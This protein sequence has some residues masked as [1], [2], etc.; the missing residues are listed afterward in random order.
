MN[1]DRAWE[2]LASQPVAVL[3]TVDIDGGP[4]LVPFVFAS[5]Q[6]RRLISAVDSKPKAS[7]RLRRLENIR[8]DSRVSVLAHHYEA[9]WTALWWVRADG[10]A[11]VSEEPPPGHERL[12]DQ[13]PGYDHHDLGP[14][15]VV[16]VERVAGWSAA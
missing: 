13:Y 3:G 7:R 15:I 6:D 12:L 8:R 9:D 11:T 10:R 14:W 1:P 16:T 4:H 2:L 5:T